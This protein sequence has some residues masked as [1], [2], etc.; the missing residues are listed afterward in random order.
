[1]LNDPNSDFK[2]NLDSPSSTRLGN[3]TESLTSKMD[4]EFKLEDDE[5]SS[6]ESNDTFFEFYDET[7]QQ[8]CSKLN[9]VEHQLNFT[10]TNTSTSNQIQYQTNNNQ[11]NQTQSSNSINELQT[12][13][14]NNNL[15]VNSNTIDN[16]LINHN[17]PIN[18]SNDL[19][20]IQY[21]NNNNRNQLP[22][23]NNNQVNKEN[24]LYQNVSNFK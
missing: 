9:Q 14:T 4:M 19:N 23:Q 15:V 16:Q 13:D 17:L 21:Q 7:S 22:I 18:F 11:I 5:E 10:N 1:M 20:Q 6:N 3:L 24:I 12:S 2:F 8:S